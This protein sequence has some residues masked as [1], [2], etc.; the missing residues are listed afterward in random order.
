MMLREEG[1]RETTLKKSGKKI[2]KPLNI[3]QTGIEK[4]KN[5]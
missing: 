2:N 3:M 4:S 1:R 5:K